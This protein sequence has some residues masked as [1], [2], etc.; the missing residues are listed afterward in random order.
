MTRV[1]SLTSD[2]LCHFGLAWTCL[3]CGWSWLLPLDLPWSACLARSSPSPMEQP[4]LAILGLHCHSWTSAQPRD[5]RECMWHQGWTHSDTS[6][7]SKSGCSKS[8]WE[9]TQVLQEMSHAGKEE[10]SFLACCSWHRPPP[11]ADIS[12]FPI[13]ARVFCFFHKRKDRSAS[14]CPSIG[15]VASLLWTLPA[16]LLHDGGPSG[17]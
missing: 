2:L 7:N 1:P 14:F 9:E 6:K 5:H 15:K 4:S 16:S 12:F 8:Q 13:S 11:A 10:V 3:D 17:W